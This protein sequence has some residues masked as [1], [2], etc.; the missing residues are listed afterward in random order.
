MIEVIKHGNTVRVYKCPNC[1]CV[2]KV[3]RLEYKNKVLIECPECET[4]VLESKH[5]VKQK[6]GY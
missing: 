4:F 2:F 3:D 6:L 1:E 5:I